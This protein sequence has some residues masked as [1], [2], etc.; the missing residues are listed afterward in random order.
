MAEATTEGSEKLVTA[1]T[2]ISNTNKE[3][4]SK[5][6]ELQ[7]EIHVANLEYKKDRDRTAAD[8]MRVS[9]LHQSAVVTAISN[10]A[11]ALGRMHE[12]EHAEAPLH[13]CTPPDRATSTPTL[14]LVL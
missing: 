5:K 1:L 4:E 13:H 10:L 14:K 7:K 8:N 3:M 2:D 6:I 9:L 12:R 11:T